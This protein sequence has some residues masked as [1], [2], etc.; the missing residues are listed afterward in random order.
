MTPLL[1]QLNWD[2]QWTVCARANDD[3]VTS[4]AQCGGQVSKGSQTSL[5]E[6]LNFMN[7]QDLT[8]KLP[9]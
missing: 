1:L 5:I 3:A 6:P 4:S 2:L 9:K 8:V 7:Q